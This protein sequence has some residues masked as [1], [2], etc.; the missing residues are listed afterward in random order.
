MGNSIFKK[1]LFSSLL[2][3]VSLS[4]LIGTIAYSI[5]SRTM[6]HETEKDLVNELKQIDR[7]LLTIVEDVNQSTEIL[8][9][10]E[11]LMQV[12]DSN[13]KQS[14]QRYLDLLE[15][16]KL[17]KTAMSN[18]DAIL[19][20]SILSRNQNFS[21][22]SRM[23]NYTYENFI[24]LPV[25]QE[26]I[27]T[28]KNDQY[29]LV[30]AEELQLTASA[31]S[32]KYEWIDKANVIFLIKKISS[33]PGNE[34][35]VISFL[36]TASIM[37][38]SNYGNV[39]ALD[40]MDR[41]VW[42]GMP[43]ID[44]SALF[45]RKASSI[46][47]PE[48]SERAGSRRYVYLKSSVMDWFLI[49]VIS[50]REIVKPLGEIRTF[51][52]LSIVVIIIVC[53]IAAMT[54]SRGLTRRI[55]HLKNAV[56]LKGT[57]DPLLRTIPYDQRAGSPFQFIHSLKFGY[58]LFL[59]YICIVIIPMLVLSILLYHK[60][61]VIVENR[62]EQSFRQPLAL[63]AS[64]IDMLMNRHIRNVK[65]LI[66]SENVQQLF[67]TPPSE[68]LEEFEKRQSRITNEIMSKTIYHTGLNN[69]EIYSHNGQLM[70][71]SSQLHSERPSDNAIIP[72]K[73]IEGSIMWEDTYSDAFQ[74]QV[75]SLVHEI[76]GNIL[77]SE[78]FA[79][80]IGYL[81]IV[82]NESLLS[83]I[84]KDIRFSEGSEVFIENRKGQIVSSNDKQFIGKTRNEIPAVS[85]SDNMLTAVKE[86]GYNDWSLQ[87][88]IPAGKLMSSKK[89][90]ITY[91]LFV[92]SIM[93]LVIVIIC[94]R[95]SVLYVRPIHALIQAMKKVK[96]G[97][98]H[99]RFQERSGDEIELLGRSFNAM[100]DRL[101]QLIEEITKSKLREQ[102]LE[103]KKRS[104][105]LNALQM[106]INPHFLYNT[107]ESINW[108]VIQNENDKAVTMMTSLADLFRIGINRGENIVGLDEELM[109][110]E[111]YITIQKIR[112]N[113][114]LN[115][116]WD[117]QLEARLYLTMKL[118]LQPLIE[119]AIY[120]G[121]ELMEGAGTIRIKSFIKEDRLILQIIDDGLGIEDERLTELMERFKNWYREPSR[122]IGLL[123]VNERI[124][125]LFGEE[126]G[127]H[128]NSK[129]NEGTIVSVTLPVVRKNAS[130]GETA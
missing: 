82:L 14:F 101:Q 117:I 35:I 124:K 91:N 114:K 7:S 107:F 33:Y 48:G 76:K 64:R 15:M 12:F 67:V 71:T 1:L 99:V 34:V 20:F 57:D 81:K 9:N 127:L 28:L 90:L 23:D 129:V 83:Q 60:T 5:A 44:E 22:G 100:L 120:H 66:T 24:E 122:S 39:Y 63:A 115:V 93:L 102:E 19:G 111:A 40:G 62:L 53:M 72:P 47:K 45:S 58:K 108:L 94:I 17:L 8:Q 27:R 112:Y 75:F 2:M 123:N 104:A 26:K 38:N 51:V 13:P 50:E 18:N 80:P 92:L 59:Y 36:S 98:L 106:Q 31:P 84:L 46:D 3:V 103:T 97:D 105:E 118:V 42:R 49:N 11:A 88:I 130:E 89:D 85:M 95:R 69:V 68:S 25:Y 21:S 30:R 96:D 78:G 119:N 121:I 128:I 52:T 4:V 54:A 43:Q 110:A 125:L 56:H 74:N 73:S 61:V 37:Q 77:F 10:N 32:F 16:D 86:L 87:A 6:I 113:D 41:L 55:R 70:Y 65:Y 29:A 116:I 109:H 126:F 79:L